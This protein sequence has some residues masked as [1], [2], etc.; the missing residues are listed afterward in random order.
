[1]SLYYN[2][3]LI[4][5]VRDVPSM[6]LAQYNALTNKPK[7]WIRTDAPSGDRGIN[8]DDIQYDG[9]T[10]V[11]DKIDE[12]DYSSDT[13]TSNMFILKKQGRIANC[14]L[15]WGNIQFQSDGFTLTATLPNEYKPSVDVSIVTKVY[16][17]SSYVDC[18]FSI[19]TY[20]Q[21]RLYD[22]FGNKINGIQPQFLRTKEVFY[23]TN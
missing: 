7:L 16:N 21:I 17:G 8:A 4:S 14:F 11:G 10:S 18:V 1:M 22:L 13:S 19:N 3:K 5:G 20:G 23:F 2:K 6:T 12:L 15:V 9:N